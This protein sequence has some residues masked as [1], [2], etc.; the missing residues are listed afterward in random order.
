M[1]RGKSR[2]P[3]NESPFERVLKKGL[4]FVD[5]AERGDESIGTIQYKGLAT[6]RESPTQLYW[7]QQRIAANAEEAFPQGG[8]RDWYL[9]PDTFQICILESVSPRGDLLEYYHFD[10]LVVNPNLSDD[11]FNPEIAFGRPAPDDPPVEGASREG[12]R[13]RR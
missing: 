12:A 1:A 11:D 9:N 13:K 4:R 2:F 3:I 7:I 5:H 10:R 6:R 8:V